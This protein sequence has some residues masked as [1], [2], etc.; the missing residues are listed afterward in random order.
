MRRYLYSDKACDTL[1]EITGSSKGDRMFG[2]G[3]QELLLILAIALIVLG[4]K[5]L[6]EVARALG[7]GISEFRKATREIKES[8][9]LEGYVRDVEEKNSEP[10]RKTLHG[11]RVETDH[12]DQAETGYRDDESGGEDAE[13]KKCG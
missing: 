13:R 9:D 10:E 5:K 3:M 12:L 1:L 7:R 2:I 4:P 6:P 8:I 11:T